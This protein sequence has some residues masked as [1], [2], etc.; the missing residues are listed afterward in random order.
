[1]VETGNEKEMAQGWRKRGRNIWIGWN[2]EKGNQKSFW[3]ET[4]DFSQP[5]SSQTI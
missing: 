5:N 3:K 4:P 2:S 1:M